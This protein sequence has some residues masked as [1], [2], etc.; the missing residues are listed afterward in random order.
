M[1]GKTGGSIS[2]GDLAQLR[3]EAEKAIRRDVEPGKQN[4][5]TSF[6]V[7]DEREVN[8]FRAQA[9]NED[10]EIEF[11]DWS[12]KEP[13]NSDRAEYIRAK[14]RERIRQCSVTAV[15]VSDQTASSDWVNWEIRE[16]ARLGKGVI[17]FHVG[18][19]PPKRLPAALIEL[20]IEPI[21]WTAAGIAR[22]IRNAT[23]K[24]SQ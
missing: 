16:S 8:A 14:I 18:E 6:V 9:K 11:N 4:V 22:A 13:Y 24:D 2:L 17:A 23:P 5:F 1:G 15:F 7:E 21:R 10:S 12:V 20:G 19:M 3:A